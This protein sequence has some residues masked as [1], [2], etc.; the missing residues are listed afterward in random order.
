MATTTPAIR[1][2]TCVWCTREFPATEM[3]H[4][5]GTKIQLCRECWKRYQGNEGE[6]E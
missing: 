2:L 4:V 1:T 6:R 5:P 3:G